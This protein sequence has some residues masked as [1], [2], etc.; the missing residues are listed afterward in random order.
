LIWAQDQ[1]GVIGAGGTIPWHLPEDLR[2]FKALTMGHA[3][4][5]GRRTWFSLPAAARPLPGRTNIVLSRELRSGAGTL[6]GGIVARDL[7]EALAV[8]QGAGLEGPAWVIGGGQVFREALPYAALA[9]VT[10]VDRPASRA[11]TPKPG[12]A[13]TPEAGNADTQEA[14]GARTP[15]ASR[16]GTPEASGAETPEAGGDTFAPVLGAGW[17]CV[18]RDPP[19]GWLDSTAHLRYR[20]ETW[21]RQASPNNQAAAAVSTGRTAPTGQA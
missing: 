6:P 4:V 13:D 1:A 9:Q 5:M 7:A 17:R 16:A 11:G 10:V 14:N 15:E 19:E 3:V 20:F 2:R 18:R 21:V 8:A 12:G